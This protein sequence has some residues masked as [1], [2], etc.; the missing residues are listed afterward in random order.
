MLN[1][2]REWRQLVQSQLMNQ[3]RFLVCAIF[4]SV[5]GLLAYLDEYLI[6]PSSHRGSVHTLAITQGLSTRVLLQRNKNRLHSESQSRQRVAETFFRHL[7][8]KMRAHQMRASVRFQL[9]LDT[10][11]EHRE[12]L[13]VRS[14]LTGESQLDQRSSHKPRGNGTLRNSSSHFRKA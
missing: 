9:I 3:Q 14:R 8:K 10:S 4:Q 13:R 5:Y 6:H 1:L 2:P 12:K 11:S 7:I